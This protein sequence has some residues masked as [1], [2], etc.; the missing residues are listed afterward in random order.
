MVNGQERARA[1]LEH[2][3]DLSTALIL[4][5]GKPRNHETRFNHEAL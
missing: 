2:Q 3:M 5:N 1:L 4:V